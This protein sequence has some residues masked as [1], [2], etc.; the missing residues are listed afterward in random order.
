MDLDMYLTRDTYVQNW[1]HMKPE[2]RHAITVKL[3]GVD[4]PHIKP[5]RISYVTEDIGYWRKANAIHQWFVDN[6]AGDEGDHCQRMYVSREQIDEL[7]D[8][9]CRIVADHSLAEELLPTQAGF[10][11][12]TTEYGE[13]YFEDLQTTKKILEDVISCNQGSIYYQASW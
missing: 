5:E 11:F 13:Y 3:N 2:E 10:F 8:I 4:V 7:Y 6:C 1:D 12:G 9:V